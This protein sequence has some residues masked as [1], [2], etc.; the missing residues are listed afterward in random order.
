VFTAALAD[1]ERGAWDDAVAKF[2][3]VVK[4]SPQ[5]VPEVI[6]VLEAQYDRPDL[7]VAAAADGDDPGALMQLAQRLRA[8]GGHEAVAQD[9]WKAGVAS[10]E[11]VCAGNDPSPGALAALGN[12]YRFDGRRDDAIGAYR[13]ALVLEYGR[14]EWRL[15]L[16]RLLNASGRRPE[17]LRE[18]QICLRL[19]PANEAARELVGELIVPGNSATSAPSGT[20]P[21]ALQRGPA[22][23]ATRPT[24]A[25][26]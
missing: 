4:L 18:A 3:R 14:V 17:A 6:S 11:R 8:K 23:G 26:R 9:A 1:A 22:P 19:Q 7:A 25:G 2:K 15:E 13:R 12:A 21:A 24:A 5:T 10:L 20:P 16:A